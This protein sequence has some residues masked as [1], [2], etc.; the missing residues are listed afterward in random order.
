MSLYV[1][2]FI[3]TAVLIHFGN[4]VVANVVPA[5][6]K[7]NKADWVSISAGWEFAV[8]IDPFGAKCRFIPAF[9][10]KSDSMTLQAAHQIHEDKPGATPGTKILALSGPII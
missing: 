8:F 6:M 9:R 4:G 5:K 10:A 1:A 2:E 3:R 7:G